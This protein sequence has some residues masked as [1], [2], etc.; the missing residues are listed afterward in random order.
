M[1][2][3][4]ILPLAPPPLGHLKDTETPSSLYNNIVRQA[5]TSN[6]NMLKKIASDHEEWGKTLLYKTI[7]LI[8]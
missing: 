1:K 8:K 7:A 5:S 4:L 6:R 2:I 3:F